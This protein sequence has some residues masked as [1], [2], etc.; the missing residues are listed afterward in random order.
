MFVQAGRHV[1]LDTLAQKFYTASSSAR[2]S[3]Y[4]EA[5][6]LIATAG[7]A[8]KHYVRVME[9]V[10]NGST[11][12]IEK[13]TKRCALITT[14]RCHL[15]QCQHFF[16]FFIIDWR[17]SYR[18]AIFP[19]PNSMS[20]RSNLTFSSHLLNQLRRKPYLE[21]RLSFECILADIEGSCMFRNQLIISWQ[22]YFSVRCQLT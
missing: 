15:Q 16:H 20:W 14:C 12:Y 17:V 8:A 3:L 9:K 2:D 6:G 21:R 10:V 13:E 19:L 7:S 4:S 18:N 5:Q 11:G 22:W 1:A